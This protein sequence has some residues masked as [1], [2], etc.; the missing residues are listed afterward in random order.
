MRGLKDKLQGLQD[1]KAGSKHPGVLPTVGS[2]WSPQPE[3]DTIS[4]LLGEAAGVTFNFYC[5]HSKSAFCDA[6]MELSVIYLLS[7]T[8]V[9]ALCINSVSKSLY[10]FCSIF[11][12]Q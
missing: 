5:C 6:Q 7:G 2:G 8:S 11:N 1:D 10:Y 3:E 4:L 9:C 12:L